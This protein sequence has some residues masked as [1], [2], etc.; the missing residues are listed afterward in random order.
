LE[1]RRKKSEHAK[2]EDSR[3]LALISAGSEQRS[4][5]AENRGEKG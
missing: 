4:E 1:K 3:Q 5:L 2:M